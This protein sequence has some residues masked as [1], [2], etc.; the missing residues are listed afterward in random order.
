MYRAKT[1]IV[2][3]KRTKTIS[4]AVSKARLTFEAGK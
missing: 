2:Q 1:E 3:G 4:E